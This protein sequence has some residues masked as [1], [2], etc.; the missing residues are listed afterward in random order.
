M[1]LSTSTYEFGE[2]QSF[3]PWHH[4]AHSE[5]EYAWRL[6]V[7][8]DL[9]S[10]YTWPSVWQALQS[11]VLMQFANP[12]SQLSA[13]RRSCNRLSYLN[14]VHVNN[15][16]SKYPLIKLRHLE[17]IRIDVL[18]YSTGNYIQSLGIEHDAT[19][20]SK[21]MYLYVRLGHNAIRQKLTQYCKATI[22]KIFNFC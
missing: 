21:R 12:K 11:Y 10:C 8:R 16:G 9:S 19:S 22:I 5:N 15:L 13:E 20:M 2:T 7:R 14:P 1:G 6:E 4:W 18:L 3:K 17:W